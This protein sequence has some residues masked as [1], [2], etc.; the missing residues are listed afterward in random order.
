[1]LASVSPAVLLTS[2]DLSVQSACFCFDQFLKHLT[3]V[4][5]AMGG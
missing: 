5:V 3:N 2:R 4:P 1:L